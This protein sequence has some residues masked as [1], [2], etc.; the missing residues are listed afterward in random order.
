ME[1]AQMSNQKNLDKTPIQSKK[2]LAYMFSN[3]CF[4]IYLFYATLH[5]EDSVV[6]ITVIVSAAFLDVGYILGQSY[7]DKYMHIGD[8]ASELLN[9]RKLLGL[10]ET[11]NRQSPSK[12]QVR[13]KSKDTSQ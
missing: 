12:T 2:F 5:Q 1:G 6:L 9:P 3:I 13:P 8:V 7:V 4:K 11:D 10:S